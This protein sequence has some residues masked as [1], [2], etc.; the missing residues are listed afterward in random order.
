MTNKA[1]EETQEPLRHESR[2][3]HFDLVLYYY[4]CL[5]HTKCIRRVRSLGIKYICTY[6]ID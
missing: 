5:V 4:V 2:G 6:S 1:E 3:S